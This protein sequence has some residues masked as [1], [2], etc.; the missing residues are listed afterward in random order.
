MKFGQYELRELIAVGGMAEVYKGR[1]VGAEGFEKYVAIK[2]ILPDLAED[3]RFVKML[4]TEARIHSALSHR[5]IVQIH[6]LGISEDGEYFIVLEY[7]EGYDLRMILDQVAAEGEIIPE[8]LSLLIASELAQGLHFAH[9][10]RG[11][12]GQPLGLVHRDVSPS[13]VLISNAGE[14]K[15]SDFGLAKR[16]ADR[17]VVGS[18]KGSL[19]YMPPEQARQEA[20]LDRRADVFSLGAVL[21]EMLTGKRLREIR[22]EV[23]GFHEV[24]AGALPSVRAVRPD[25]P[26]PFERLLSRALAPEPEA[27]FADAAVFGAAIRFVLA[28]M[29]TPVGASD[30][31]LLLSTLKPARRP[32]A[33]V[34][35]SSK[36]IRLGPEA[37]ALGVAIARTPR[38]AAAPGMTPATSRPPGGI[39]NLA[40]AGLADETDDDEV[41]TEARAK[42]PTGAEPP[43]P[44]TPPPLE[45]LPPVQPWRAPPNGAAPLARVDRGTPPR[46]IAS[47][48]AEPGPRLHSSASANAPVV[49]TAFGAAAV[50]VAVERRPATAERLPAVAPPVIAP[51][52]RRETARV[53]VRSGATWRPLAL[54]LVAVLLLVAGGVHLFVVP[55]EVLAVWSKP[56]TLAVA[57]EPAGAIVKLDGAALAAPSPTQATVRRDRFDHLLE[58]A[59]PGYRPARQTIRYDGAVALSATVRLE[60]E[61]PSLEPLPAKPA[62]AP[63]TASP[64]VERIPTPAAAAPSATKP[65]PPAPKSTKS[66]S[67]SMKV[68]AHKRTTK[69]R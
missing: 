15:V 54:A 31:Q 62:P 50:A 40:A 57:T 32:R 53:V 14:V 1:V 18:L 49:A 67:R 22:D 13:N 19:S 39:T 51:R 65:R 33:L 11:A 36:V 4:L 29:N 42:R 41:I 61:A 26:E 46:P 20:A 66:G 45:P 48:S 44:P 63:P 35:E 60:K 16:R 8:A 58:I 47:A 30:L 34:P 21:F 38:P 12:D 3:E 17:S 24:A 6:D 2:R 43:V 64:V 23:T 55:L 10:Q 28:G 59:A 56:A 25:L 27:R 69:H 37:Q 9:E 52:V 5:N 68:A 7:V